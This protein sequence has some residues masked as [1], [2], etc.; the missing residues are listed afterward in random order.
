MVLA[1]FNDVDLYCVNADEIFK[2]VRDFREIE[3]DYLTDEQREVMAEYFGEPAYKEGFDR[4]VESYA[5]SSDAEN[6]RE[7]GIKDRFIMLWQSLAPLY[8]KLNARLEAEGLSYPG[9]SYR[10]ALKRVLEKARMRCGATKLYLSD[11]MP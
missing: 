6:K 2:N 11:S 9:M 1:D 8:H 3:T 5:Y 10:L 7:T 4:F